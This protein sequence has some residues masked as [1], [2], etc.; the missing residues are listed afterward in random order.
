MFELF[1]TI[2]FLDILDIFLFALLL[3]EIYMLIRGSVAINI[4]AGIFLVYLLWLIVRS[5][6]MQLLSTMLGQFIG[7]GVIALIIVFQ[8]ELRR[9]LLL[10]GTQEVF[11]QKF[12]FRNFLASGMSATTPD[13][14]KSIVT[15][16]TNMAK[17]HT[18]ALIVLATKTELRSYIAT[19]EVI[20]SEI[21]SRL[22][23]TVF[24]K[25]NPLHDGALII[26]GNKIRAAKCVLPVSN[27]IDL[28]DNMGLRH[29][30]GLSMSRETD[31]IVIIVSEERGKISYA[32][33]GKLKSDI[34]PQE[35]ERMLIEH[36][37]KD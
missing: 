16:C 8:P 29:R 17:S 24:F 12:S 2:R 6:R 26:N 32:F 34:D 25:N 14:I 7:V 13:H 23:E 4:F 19:G 3:Y 18:G 30:A 15:A 9:F 27:E 1:I 36:Y 20:N 33:N 22:I 35:L 28:P 31:G 11:A 21:S 5:L 37:Y 10:V